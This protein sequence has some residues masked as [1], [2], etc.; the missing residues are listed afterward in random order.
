M[1]QTDLDTGGTQQFH[2]E[3]ASVRAKVLQWSVEQRTALV[4]ELIDTIARPQST[5]VQRVGTLHT[6]LGLLRTSNPA[7]SDEQVQNWLD[8]YR[9]EKYG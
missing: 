6:A 5:G 7:P 1:G 2:T 3:Y 8:E 9:T 4:H